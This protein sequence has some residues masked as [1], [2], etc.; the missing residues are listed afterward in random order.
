MVERGHVPMA[1]MTEYIKVMDECIG[2]ETGVITRKQ[3]G[4]CFKLGRDAVATLVRPLSK[5]TIGE[6][7]IFTKRDVAE[8]LANKYT[9]RSKF[10]R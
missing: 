1:T 10:I 8:A 3:I 7:D 4:K 5:I 2:K 6:G 9:E